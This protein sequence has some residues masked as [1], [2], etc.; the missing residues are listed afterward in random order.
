MQLLGVGDGGTGYCTVYRSPSSVGLHGF[1]SP[2]GAQGW[3]KVENLFKGYR[4]KSKVIETTRSFQ[5]I[6]ATLSH[7]ILGGGTQEGIGQFIITRKSSSAF[8]K[9]ASLTGSALEKVAGR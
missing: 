7:D 5:V 6:D 9:S 4:N 8:G 1:G 2:P 3:R